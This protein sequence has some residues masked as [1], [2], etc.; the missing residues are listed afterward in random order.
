MKRYAYVFGFTVCFLILVSCVPAMNQQFVQSRISSLEESP[1]DF[2]SEVADSIIAHNLETMTI[3]Y[4]CFSFPECKAQVVRVKKALPK[5]KIRIYVNAMELFANPNELNQRP[6]QN[7]I[8]QLV[9]SDMEKFYLSSATGEKIVYWDNPKML[10][11]NLSD[12][13]PRINGKVYTEF[14]VDN[15]YK[16]VYKPNRNLI[17]GIEI[18]NLWPYVSWINEYRGVQIDLDNDGKGED[19][20]TLDYAWRQGIFHMVDYIRAKFPKGFIVTGRG[21]HYRYASKM[22]GL[23]FETLFADHMQS[24]IQG[25]R[26]A[27]VDRWIRLS[28]TGT[29]Y[30]LNEIAGEDHENLSKYVVSL[31]GDGYFALDG[32]PSGHGVFEEFT[33]YIDL[34]QPMAATEYPYKKIFDSTMSLD[35]LSGEFTPQKNWLRLNPGQTMEMPVK[36]GQQVQFYY[37]IL[38]GQYCV[39]DV[40]FVY[41]GMPK[42]DKFDAHRWLDGEYYATATEDGEVSWTYN[43]KGYA[44]LTHIIVRDKNQGPQYFMRQYEK[45]TVVYNPD[46][47]KIDLTLHNTSFSLEPGQGKILLF[48]E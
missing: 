27:R 40:K 48:K 4:D 43:G 37:Q 8:A 17:D 28:S 5:I 45:G 24:A 12:R 22:D 32:G 2:S 23:T 42:E 36:E 30:T 1:N 19:F 41:P 15:L 31:L 16:Y 11:M 21:F 25:G 6:V 35:G 47:E 14:L 18:D 7:S 39:C 29:H 38:N 46:D 26:F 44:L 10:M 33:G 20:W 3:D 9:N 34:G 13:C